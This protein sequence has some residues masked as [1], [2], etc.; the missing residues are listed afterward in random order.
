[1]DGPGMLSC[2]VLLFALG[3]YVVTAWGRSLENYGAW[4]VLIFSGGQEQHFL[5]SL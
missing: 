2:P 1:M 3:L 5:A 4:D